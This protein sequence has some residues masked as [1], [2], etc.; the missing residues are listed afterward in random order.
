[1]N[2]QLTTHDSPMKNSITSR[3]SLNEPRFQ[4]EPLKM[5]KA[6]RSL[7]AFMMQAWPVLEPATPFV[8]GIHVEAICTHL[9]AVTEGRI[10][11]LIINVPPGHAKSLLTG[12]F[13]PAWAWIEHPES[14]WLFSSYRE[15]LAIRDSLKC[16]R[17]IESDWY[18]QR[19]S[20]RFQLRDDQNQKQRFEND[21][22]GYRVVVP[23]SAGTGE[24]GDYVVVDD[25]H[26]VDQAASDTERQSAVEW[27]NGSMATRLND[28]SSGHKIVIMQ[29]LHE[30]DLTGDLLA[31]G[32]YDLL[33]LPAEF[34]PGR[35]CATSI[36]WS[37]PRQESG[38]LLWPEKVSRADLD[39][40]KIT[41][42]SYRYAAQ[43]QQ[44]PA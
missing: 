12:V 23:M 29:R 43:Y 35:R 32:G 3:G 15:P 42:G 25:P 4:M 40:L 21:R 6:R 27:W 8:D 34:E 5:E 18:Q 33:C 20:S 17:L 22:T 16:R 26:S 2:Q 38:E 24:R 31:K 9:Q 13:W 28:L 19:W 10:S 41:L 44:R 1:M 36:G 30:S 7:K 39:G 37:D 11:N 14:R